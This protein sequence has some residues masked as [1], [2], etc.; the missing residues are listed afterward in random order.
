M[1]KDYKYQSG[2]V[3]IFLALLLIFTNADLFAQGISRKNG[4]GV[5]FG[6]WKTA[7]SS[8]LISFSGSRFEVSGA[9]AWMFYFSRFSEEWFYEF[10]L[11]AFGSVVV[12][13]VS[14]GAFIFEEE[15]VTAIIPFLFGVRYDFLGSQSQSG[16]Q[17][18]I[19]IGAGTYW[20]T[21]VDPPSFSGTI[22][23][24]E[25]GIKPGG[26]AGGGLNIAVASW[27]EFNFDV[28]YHFFDFKPNGKRTTVGKQ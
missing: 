27:L 22:G 25:S 6:L 5:R 17:P 18:Y 24:M 7:R 1:L 3:F 10:Y 9:G 16:L 11:G 13:D 15:D 4:L 28:K 12:N 2:F 8:A 26:Y 23:E 20:I 19:A 21:N 14:N